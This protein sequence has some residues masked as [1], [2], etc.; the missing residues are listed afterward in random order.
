MVMWD[1]KNSPFLSRFN[2]LVRAQRSGAD[3][4]YFDRGDK[5]GA[6]AEVFA[7]EVRV[8]LTDHAPGHTRL[9]VDKVMLHELRSLEALGFEIMDGEEVTEKSR[10]VKGPDE[11]RAIRCSSHACEVAVRRMEDFARANVGDGV[12]CENDI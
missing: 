3:L 9:P 5:N 11:I 10:A 6:Q 2:P 7:N 1:Y 4:F 12:T 8:L